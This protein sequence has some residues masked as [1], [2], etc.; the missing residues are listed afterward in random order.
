MR[1]LQLWRI[2]AID[3]VT[4]RGIGKTR[5]KREGAGRQSTIQMTS[6]VSASSPS[7]GSHHAG[8]PSS[9]PARHD[10]STSPGGIKS[11]FDSD[12]VVR[13]RGVSH[14]QLQPTGFG[15]CFLR[16]ALL[17]SRTCV[18]VPHVAC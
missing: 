18:S 17:G 12:W 16:E 10:A 11:S 1:A 15:R 13:D 8:R 6:G 3:L 14:R 9:C 4:R 7:L 2:T 5:V